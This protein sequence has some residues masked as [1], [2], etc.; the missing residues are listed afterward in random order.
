MGYNMV[1]WRSCELLVD[2]NLGGATWK[3]PLALAGL[4]VRQTGDRRPLPKV[5]S[6]FFSAEVRK[7]TFT[8][9]NRLQELFFDHDRRPL[10]Q[11]A[12]PPLIFW[13]R[14]CPLDIY[15][16]IILNLKYHKKRTSKVK[17][18]VV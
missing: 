15:H 9:S 18:F 3:Y 2:V 6:Y 16:L 14:P 4:A 1:G 8:Q 13:I 12:V 17:V 7:K 5:F 11:T 10:R